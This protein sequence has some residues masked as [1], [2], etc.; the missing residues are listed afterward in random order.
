MGRFYSAP[1]LGIP[2]SRDH[3]YMVNII[4]SAI[5]NKPP[6]KAVANLIAWSNKTHHLDT[7]T[8]EKMMKFFDK[9]PGARKKTTRFNFITMPR[10]NWT[11]LT[12]NCIPKDFSLGHGNL[13]PVMST[14]ISSQKKKQTKNKSHCSWLHFGEIGAGT[15]H[16]A[17]NVDQHGRGTDGGLDVCIR[18]EI[19]HHDI[20]GKTELYGMTIPPLDILD[21]C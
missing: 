13:A 5:V 16:K 8:D 20:H 19:D 10:R 17:A 15:L 9:D 2:I 21:A 7:S 12:E 1:K 6:P 14:V 4:S 11:M 3:R 18:V